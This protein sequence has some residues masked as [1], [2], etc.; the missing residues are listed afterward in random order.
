VASLAIEAPGARFAMER[1]SERQVLT[2]IRAPIR[3]PTAL[4]VQP[5]LVARCQ[6]ARPGRSSGWTSLEQTASSG[7]FQRWSIRIRDR[8]TSRA[9]VVSENHRLTE[10]IR[11][12]DG[13]GCIGV[14]SGSCCSTLSCQATYRRLIIGQGRDFAARGFCQFRVNIGCND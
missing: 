4:L 9:S 14:K 1:G 10:T 3:A 7:L 5:W 2:P 6:V 11:Q 8:P 13:Y 12:S